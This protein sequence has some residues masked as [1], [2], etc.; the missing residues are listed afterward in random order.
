MDSGGTDGVEQLLVGAS[1]LLHVPGVVMYMRVRT[2]SSRP[3]P[4][5]CN[6]A[7][8]ALKELTACSYGPPSTIAPSIT[9]VRPRAT[10]TRPFGSSTARE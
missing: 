3:R 5:C 9:E 7:N 1:D 10:S 4:S 6:A 8:A 2:T